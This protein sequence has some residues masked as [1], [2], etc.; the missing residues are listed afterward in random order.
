M[1]TLKIF[2]VIVLVSGFIP[3]THILC[4]TGNLYAGAAKVNITPE[5]PVMM[6]GYAAR[7]D[8]S[9]GV[10]DSLYARILVLDVTG[11]RVAVISCDL[12]K[13]T[14]KRILDTAR[15]RFNIPHV[16]ICSSHT[17]SGPEFGDYMSPVYESPYARS[18]EKAMIDALLASAA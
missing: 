1:K 14:N 9:M 12:I 5:E 11:Y 3:D 4:E 7:K 17:H 2:F 10:H 18:V 13:Y 16:L 6:S 8:P 15:E